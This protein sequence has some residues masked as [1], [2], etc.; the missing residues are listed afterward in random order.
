[1]AAKAEGIRQRG[2]DLCLARHVRRVIE[3]AL[4]VLVFQVD[5]GGRGALGECL[6][7]GDGLDRAAGRFSCVKATWWIPSNTCRMHEPLRVP[8]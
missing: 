5:R 6:D 1:M 2:P 7:C 8:R 3:V 4:G